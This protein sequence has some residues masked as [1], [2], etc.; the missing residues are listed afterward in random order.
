MATI[1]PRKNKAGKITGYQVKIRR[2][3]Y[4][5]Q[6]ETFP[7]KAKAIEWARAQE[8]DM[9]SGAWRDRTSA[10]STTL[11]SLLD[12]YAK[13]VTPTK[14][15]GDIEKLRIA[16]L[17][18]DELAKYKLSAL[19]PLVLANWRDRRVADGCAGSTV[20]RELNIISAVINWARKELMIAIE[21]PV[22]GIR[23]PPQPPGRDRRLED[24][25]EGRLVAA[26]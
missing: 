20:N 4:P 25:E 2:N 15:G 23:R 24:D 18:R 9:D 26:L 13:D 8:A 22:S 21:N 12:R 14:R 7:R 10:D 5:H 16:T 11:Y 17:Q 6:S 1:T 3:G 19:S